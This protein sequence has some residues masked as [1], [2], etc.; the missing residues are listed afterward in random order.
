MARKIPGKKRPLIAQGQGVNL[1]FLAG[2]PR[3]TL[4]WIRRT[5]E[6]DT[7]T[8][9]ARFEGAP[10]TTN[11]WSKLYNKNTITEIQKSIGLSVR[12]RGFDSAPPPRRIIVLYVPSNDA[13]VLMAELG[14][15]CYLAPLIPEDG[16]SSHGNEIG[17]RHHKDAA[18]DIVYR[19]L[20]SA[21]T[22]TNALKAEIT[23]KRVSFFSLPARNFYFPENDSTILKTYQEFTQRK[24][25][26][27]ELR[28]SLAPTRFMRS[29]LPS[30]AFKGRQYTDRFFQD[31]RGRVFPPDNHAFNRSAEESSVSN[32]QELQ[33]NRQPDAIQVLEQRYRFGVTV[34][35]GNRHYDVQYEL[36]RKLQKEPMHCAAMGDVWI[37]GSHANVGVNDVVW[38]PGG[39]IERRMPSEII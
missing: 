4:K 14:L 12:E 28:D 25:S 38:A 13:Q 5:L 36:P 1:V 7:S 29:Q 10:S 23:D 32:N 11:D 34:R 31:R 15:A 17:W 9:P 19:A 27:L 21:I 18:Q 39:K 37:T 30:R 35:D 3:E 8:I 2:L 20:R 26:L 22:E 6:R 24:V 16:G 33:S